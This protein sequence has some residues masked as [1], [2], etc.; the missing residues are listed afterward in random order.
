MHSILGG[1]PDVTYQRCVYNAYEDTGLFG[2]Y[3]IGNEV[4]ATQMAYVS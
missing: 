4:F 2:N 1:L 3:I